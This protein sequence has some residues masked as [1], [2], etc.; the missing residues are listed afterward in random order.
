MDVRSEIIRSLLKDFDV[1]GIAKDYY[2]SKQQML[3]MSD[4]GMIFGSH[5]HKH[6]LVSQL[7]D[8]HQLHEIATAHKFV[9]DTLN[10][11]SASYCHPYGGRHS[12]TQQTLN[13]L[14][15]IGVE[16]AFSVDSRPIELKDLA[17][18]K[19]YQLP[20]FNCNEFAFGKVYELAK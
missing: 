16:Y 7:E 9:I 11:T 19:K 12:F 1:V 4:G 6:R 10:Q 20:R 3:E 14:S 8:Q 17:G 13:I 2:L 15:K 5:T 18:N